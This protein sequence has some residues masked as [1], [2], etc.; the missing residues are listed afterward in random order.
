MLQEEFGWVPP[1]EEE[2]TRFDIL[3]VVLQAHP[4][5]EPKVF[6][7]P[8]QYVARVDMS[9]P[10]HPGFADLGL[11]WYAVPA[12][13]CLELSVGGLT[14]TG[15]PFN[16]WYAVT[17]IVRNLTE[18]GRYDQCPAVA[19]LLGLDTR[20]D[21]NMWRD[22]AIVTVTQ[23]VMH[24]FRTA[25][26]GM[27]DHHTLMRNFWGWYNTEKSRRG[28]VPGNWKWI[29][30]PVSPTA[31]RCYL[32]L[33]HMTEY[34]I[35]PGYWYA[36][37][38]RSYLKRLKET[39]AA[40][41]AAA[42]GGQRRP[43]ANGTHSNAAGGAVLEGAAAKQAVDGVAAAAG[44][45]P[46]KLG[47]VFIAYASVTGTTAKYAQK[48]AGVLS[49]PLSV[50]ALDMEDF[51]PDSWSEHIRG[52]KLVVLALSTYGPGAAPSTAGK[53]MA[54]LQKGLAIG[55]EAHE[56]LH[57]KPFAVLGFGCTSYPRFCAAA[58]SLYSLV[59][60]TGATPIVSTG[61]V[62]SLSHEEATVWSWT[63]ELLG[64]VR[65]RGSLLAPEAL[66][67]AIGRIPMTTDGT[68]KPFVP[69][70]T[71]IDLAGVENIRAARDRF[72]QE[73]RVVEVREL[74][75]G[76]EGSGDKSAGPTT[77]Q[78]IFDVRK[79]NGG[80]LSYLAGDELAVWGEN[81]EDAV[82]AVATALGLGGSRL[83]SM[84]LLQQ[85]SAAAAAGDD[86]EEAKAAEDAAAAAGG[87]GS[88]DASGLSCAPFPLPNTYRTILTSYVALCDAPS[89]E[90]VRALALY[91]PQDA[92]LA[93]Y[94]R[95]YSA[96]QA[97]AASACVRWC[98]VW[99][100]FPALAGRLPVEVFLQLVPV[101]KPRHYSISSSAAHHPGQL[102]LTISRLAYKLP[103]GETR[104]GFCSSFLA[105][106]REGDRVSVKVLPTPGFRMPLDPAAPVIMVAAGT[107]VAP[108]KSFWEERLARAAKAKERAGSAAAAASAA[109]HQEPG[110][111]VLIFG[112][113]NSSEDFIYCDT[114]Q[115]AVSKGALSKVLTAFSRDPAQR[116]QY[117]QDVV[118]THAPDLA[119]LLRNKACHVYVCGSSNMATE[120][121]LAFRRVLGADEYSALVQAGRYH[122][123]V[124]GMVV[125]D[126]RAAR[127]A[128]AAKG[129]ITLLGAAPAAE[130]AELLDGGGLSLDA[131]DHNGS[132]LLHVA[133][134]A[135][136][137][138]LV[139]LLLERG[140]GVNVLDVYGC[141]P[142]QLARA[143]AQ[144][145]LAELIQA[146]GG[147]LT[148]LL[149]SQYYPVHKAV[150]EGDVEALRQ[151]LAR[152]ANL[153]AAEYHGLTPLHVACAVASPEIIQMLIDA[154]A[155]LDAVTRRGLLPLQ[156]AL[157][158]QR[159]DAAEQLKAA[160][161]P[162]IIKQVVT[163][164][165]GGGAGGGGGG[166][167]GAV[168]WNP[169]S[170]SSLEEAV[171]MSEDEMAALQGSWAALSGNAFPEESKK[172]LEDFGVN[173]FLSLF[174]QCP[175]LLVLFPFKDEQGKPITAE[176]RI[177]GAKVLSTL[178]WTVQMFSN[179][180]NLIRTTEDL[181]ERHVAY[182]VELAHY[183]LL[184]G[185][186]SQVLEQTLGKVLWSG[187]T[188]SAWKKVGSIICAVA[189]TVYGRRQQQQ[190]Q[191]QQEEQ[192]MAP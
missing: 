38:W 13:S 117:V 29:I 55:G 75:R 61:K 164:D 24:S 98:D 103:S 31:S 124:F 110:H 17:E 115:E 3:P 79:V 91:A 180:P 166:G 137:G 32:E 42:N 92:R 176:L 118:A 85:R 104:V 66:E 127:K 27:V 34:T 125:P 72:R 28:Y 142:L 67:E 100:E 78:V 175:Q 150:M 120:V 44:E 123:D 154:K 52:A 158:L 173:F 190:Q 81:P 188:D 192:E 132:S 5:Q 63:R 82:D 46:S 90:A 37:M 48:L 107:G 165:G 50:T 7:L 4:D 51:E 182:G 9:H 113:R 155:P 88:A 105:S 114:I 6:E 167:G 161:A 93:E 74:L 145:A 116:K 49:G 12:V 86:G 47:R 80:G 57:G 126:H 69:N 189:E 179:F 139:E 25:S 149:V 171:G 121:A 71:L 26:Y 144:P 60:A 162:L 129:A 177:H 122:E 30:P 45:E 184:F 153:A 101:I 187:T 76:G 134:R 14:Y 33:N 41:A 59:C 23:A 10:D 35:K 147:K 53:F 174:D 83:E 99:K 178:G 56:A 64:S 19:A 39:R 135:R 15:C 138:P 128:A 68:P 40:K 102:H 22:Q 163:A 43:T 89:W 191:Q 73:A 160:G 186:L 54:W 130:V 96:Y 183:Y 151:L 112:C 77:K 106:R 119:P 18:E 65:Q 140:C 146:R 157:V 172:L 159:S 111:G 169:S 109:A 21:T 148:S 8:P 16:G 136:N 20:T 58:D 141:T 62:D 1:P 181:V 70:F 87:G 170:S 36:P 133:V 156:L 95:S 97:W 94:A 131:A 152:G 2:R 11:Q 108:F 168:A 185:V 84:F 143:T